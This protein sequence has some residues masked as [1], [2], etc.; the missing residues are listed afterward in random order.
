MSFA[1]DLRESDDIFRIIQVKRRADQLEDLLAD[2]SHAAFI[3]MTCQAVRTE[4]SS[5]NGGG[6][7]QDDISPD[8]FV[9][10]DQ[11][12]AGATI[13]GR[14]LEQGV[15]ILCA[16]ERNIRQDSAYRERTGRCEMSGGELDRRIESARKAFVQ[17][18]RARILG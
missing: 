13:A 11:H 3:T 8:A 4:A 9:R 12:Y 2:S 1:G 14:G 17:D 6:L 18:Y 7:T 10:R 15:Y 16:G 5:D